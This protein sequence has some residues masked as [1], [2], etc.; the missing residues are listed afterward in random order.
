MKKIK[1]FLK[2]SDNISMK[3]RVRY[4]NEKLLDIITKDLLK[5]TVYDTYLRK[6]Y[7]VSEVMLY[8]E[9]EKDKTDGFIKCYGNYRQFIVPITVILKIKE[10]DI[11]IVRY[12]TKDNRFELWY[13]G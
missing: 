3:E 12:E 6:V 5:Y 13:G 2:N 11:D 10:S 4:L 1:D 9:I 8:N 7:I